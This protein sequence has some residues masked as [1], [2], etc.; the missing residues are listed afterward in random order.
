MH[1]PA[2]TFTPVL[3]RMLAAKRSLGVLATGGA[4]G[5]LYFLWARDNAQPPPIDYETP[6]PSRKEQI[7]TLAQGTKSNP[8]DVLIIG[9]GA[10]GAGCALDA[11]TRGLKT[12]MIENDDFGAGTSSRSTKL[13][14]GG[15]RYLEKAVFNLDAGQLNL[16]FEALH[17]RKN[18][19]EN[20]P[21]LTNSLPIMTPCY[22]WWEIPYYWMGLK[23]YDLVASGKG[24]TMSRFVT[25][26]ESR[27]QFPTLSPSR[28]DGSSLKGTILYYDGQFNDSRLNVT[29]A[30]TA[31]LAGATVLN[32]MTCTNLIKSDDGRVIGCEVKDN[33]SGKTMK[34]FAKVILNATGPF[35]DGIRRMSKPDA[36][37]MIMP[38][39]GVH[40]TLPDYYSPNNIGMIVPKTKDGRI[41]FM[42][43]WLEHTIAGTT[44]S[45]SEI[46]MLPKPTE[47]E[48]QFIL[49]AI[50]DYLTVQ[51]RASDVQSAWSGIRPLAIDP[52]ASD[53][54]SAS[55]DHVVSV[56]EDKLITVGG[57]KW[58]TYRKMAEDGI[59]AA[60]SVGELKPE[61][62]CC[63]TNLPL[64]GAP[65]YTPVTFTEVAQNYV[66]PHRPGAIDTRVAEHLA[67]AYGDRARRVTQIAEEKGLGKRVVRGHPI[68]EAEVIY[69]IENEYCETIVDFIARRTRLAF[70]DT[71]ATHQALSRVGDLMAK[72]LGWGS[73]RK[74]AQIQEA[75]KFLDTFAYTG[76]T[77]VPA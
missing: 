66:V 27:R 40:I 67:H 34:A 76:A 24:L 16:V 1:P 72:Q 4:L 54:A 38:S 28:S 42:L 63:T 70:L 30:C 48:V 59:D 43:P 41:V 73:G 23:A 56:E 8:F 57:G 45:S 50:A 52:T 44:D 3:P 26:K 31:A 33:I 62:K 18:L 74:R 49:D 14:H 12:A 58:T 46:T 61:R 22:K 71:M 10:T 6:V 15:V 68:I 77:T 55:R 13:V 29:L 36:E 2:Q 69:A 37:P 11:A 32:H 20:A 5:G 7:S 9:G 35:A 17:E 53:T 75:K 64:L 25:A 21:H 60:I 47:E 19:L 65:E 39:A 51:V